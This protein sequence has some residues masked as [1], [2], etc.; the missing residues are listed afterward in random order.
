M[1]Q[2]FN[3]HHAA[4]QGDSVAQYNMGVMYAYGRGV[5]QD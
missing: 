3:F 1:N 2:T 5:K 4:T